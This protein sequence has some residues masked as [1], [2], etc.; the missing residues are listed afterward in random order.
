[1]REHLA[2]MTSA[3]SVEP[4]A[5]SG[6]VSGGACLQDGL[7]MQEAEKEVEDLLKVKGFESCVQGGLEGWFVVCGQGP[8]S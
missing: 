1:M 4:T 6:R 5:G 7:N 8:P 2:G 3:P